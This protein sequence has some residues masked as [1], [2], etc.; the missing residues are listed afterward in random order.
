M[1]IANKDLVANLVS[2]EVPRVENLQDML[3]IVTKLLMEQHFYLVAYTFD[4]KIYVRIS[5]NIYNEESDYTYCSSVAL[6]Y[7][8]RF[9][10]KSK[11]TNKS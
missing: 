10:E 9:Y 11:E 5:A 3:K 4:G 2:V 6:S 1:L 8:N 7:I